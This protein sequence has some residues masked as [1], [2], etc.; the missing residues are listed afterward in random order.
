MFVLIKK[1]KKS[2]VFN[3]AIIHFLKKSLEFLMFL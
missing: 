2:C 3:I 1:K